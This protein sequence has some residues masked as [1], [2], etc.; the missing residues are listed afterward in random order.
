MSAFLSGLLLHGASIL[1]SIAMQVMRHENPISEAQK[2]IGSAALLS[3]SLE[4][5]GGKNPNSSDF[6]G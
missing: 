2:V 1:R 5:A 6:A 4:F 3:K